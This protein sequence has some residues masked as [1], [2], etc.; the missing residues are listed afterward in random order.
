MTNYRDHKSRRSRDIEDIVAENTALKVELAK[1]KREAGI[2]IALQKKHI[3]SLTDRLAEKEDALKEARATNLTMAGQIERMAIDLAAAQGATAD[4]IA[5]FRADFMAQAAA[6]FEIL[7]SGQTELGIISTGM[8]D[9]AGR[10]NAGG[11][12]RIFRKGHNR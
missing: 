7:E 1:V 3:A 6:A 8:A 9:Y 10:V 5:A 12:Q 4:G 2:K 11:G